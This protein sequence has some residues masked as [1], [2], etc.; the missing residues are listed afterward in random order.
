MG[1]L[2]KIRPHV[3]KLLY[4][5]TE[6]KKIKSN[7]PRFSPSHNFP[8][9]IQKNTFTFYIIITKFCSLKKLMFPT[10]SFAEALYRKVKQLTV[11]LLTLL[12]YSDTPN[13]N[14][15]LPKLKTV[16]AILLEHCK[17]NILTFSTA[18]VIL[19][20]PLCLFGLKMRLIMIMFFHKMIF[21]FLMI[22]VVSPT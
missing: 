4:S 13:F 8:Q 5:N 12:H 22:P 7:P 18:K 3:A 16:S 1:L 19:T 2:D 9:M 17:E 14:V 11:K 10:N 21:Y 20:V 6:G 15:P